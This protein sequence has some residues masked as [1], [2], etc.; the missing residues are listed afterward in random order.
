[1]NRS[2]DWTRGSVFRTASGIIAGAVA[3][4]SLYPATVIATAEASVL[5]RIRP[6]GQVQL[7]EDPA[8]KPAPAAA[9]AA[10]PATQEAEAGKMAAA[11]AAPPAPAQT[12]GQSGDKVYKTV[13]LACHA[14]GVAGAPKVGDKASWG[15]R[16]KQ[17]MDALVQSVIK[18]KNVMPPKGGNPSLTDAEIH[19][20]V[21]YMLVETGLTAN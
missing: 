19:A 12:S 8:S 7:K 5:E 6:V 9:S 1:M 10:E 18:G 17:G 3:A 2:G 14:A 21:E 20:A 11:P 13:C 4:L 16:H 15:D